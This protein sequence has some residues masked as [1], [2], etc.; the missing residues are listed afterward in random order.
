MNKTL[1]VFSNCLFSLLRN[2][3]AAKTR[4]WIIWLLRHYSYS[5]YW[6]KL[7]S[8]HP[9]WVFLWMENLYWTNVLFS[10]RKPSEGSLKFKLR[11]TELGETM[12]I[13]RKKTK[14][15]V[16]L[17][18]FQML[19]FHICSSKAIQLWV[20]MAQKLL[21]FRHQLIQPFFKRQENMDK[22]EVEKYDI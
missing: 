22:F 6:N 4:I 21:L 3:F 13:E 1:Q 9:C 12:W 20:S 7:E 11:Q 2:K 15:H 5:L 8:Q 19:S 16:K 18:I 14:L 17:I 10:R